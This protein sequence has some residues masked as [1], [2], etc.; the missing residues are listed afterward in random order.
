[1]ASRCSDI[2]GEFARSLRPPSTEDNA[3]GAA[4]LRSFGPTLMGFLGKA[5]HHQNYLAARRVVEL[6]VDILDCGSS[7]V[8]ALKSSVSNA[9]LRN[10]ACALPTFQDYALQ[11][12]TLELLFRLSPAQADKKRAFALDVFTKRELASEF[13]LLRSRQ[14][15]ADARVYLNRLNSRSPVQGGRPASVV[16]LK[17]HGIAFNGVSLK[18]PAGASFFWLDVNAKSLS[19]DATLPGEQEHDF[20]EIPYAQVL[21]YS[22][23]SAGS[24][25]DEALQVQLATGWRAATAIRAPGTNFVLRRVLLTFYAAKTH[26]TIQVDF[27]SK[28]PSTDSW[29]I[30]LTTVLRERVRNFCRLV[31]SDFYVAARRQSVRDHKRGRR[32]PPPRISHCP[33]ASRRQR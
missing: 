5:P 33:H 31:L 28:Q 7:L 23:L 30:L 14:F 3:L 29:K 24:T 4:C 2:V 1:M 9:A 13:C 22:F 15:E 20:V 17:A 27:A 32:P 8:L 10:C 16:A 18:P 6:I 21:R 26:P 11:T 25:K 12:G 19:F